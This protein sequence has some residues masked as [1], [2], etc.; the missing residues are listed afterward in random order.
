MTTQLVHF[1]AARRE[2]ELARSID[3]V[4]DI[5]DKAEAIRQYARQSKQ[6]ID[7][8]NTAAEIKLRADRKIGDLLGDLETSQGKRNDLTSDQAGPKLTKREAIAGA[9]ISRGDAIRCEKIAS[10]PDD[11]FEQQVAEKKEERKELT[12]AGMLRVAKKLK[13]SQFDPIPAPVLADKSPT[14]LIGLADDLWQLADASVDLIIT[15]PPYNLNRDNW[16]M[17]GADDLGGRIPRGDGIG[18]DNYQDGQPQ[19][20]YQAWQISVLQ[21]LYRVATPGASLFYNHKPRTKNGALIHPI[22]WLSS[23]DNPWT[24]RQEIIWDRGSTHNHSKYLFWPE[25]ERIYWLTKGKPE[26]PD[27]PVGMSTVWKFHGPVASTWHPAP[28]DEE[29]PRHCIEAVGRDGITVLDPF[30]GSCTTARV[31]LEYGYDAVA[32]DISSDYL[33]RAATE[34]GWEYGRLEAEPSRLRS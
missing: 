31:A 7:I 18:Y 28:F 29:L 23:P 3:E 9:D 15:S 13:Q 12:S 25:D 27:R 32:V 20:V 19:E 34:H 10:I 4:K 33:Q 2:I 24:I 14:L 17:G 22:E 8:Q 6:G 30:A 21:E 26:L 5:R 1:D 11:I 16:P